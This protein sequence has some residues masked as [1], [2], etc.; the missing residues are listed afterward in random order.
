M[1]KQRDIARTRSD[2][3]IRLLCGAFRF[4]KVHR[5]NF[6]IVEVKLFCNICG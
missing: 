4:G 6:L 3:K 5:K 2:G 1:N